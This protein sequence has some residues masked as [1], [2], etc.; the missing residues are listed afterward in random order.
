MLLQHVRKIMVIDC[1]NC[2]AKVDAKVLAQ[3][4]T[5]D[6]DG[7]DDSERF[8]FC[9]CPACSSILLAKAFFGQC[10]PDDFDYINPR[11]LWPVSEQSAPF[12]ESIPKLVRKSLNEARTCCQAR[13]YSASVVMS[14]RAIEAVCIEHKTKSR[15]LAGGIRELKAQGVIDGRLFDWSEALRERRNIGAHATEEDVSRE[16]AEDVLNFAIAIC[17]YVFVLSDRYKEFIVRSKKRKL[18]PGSS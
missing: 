7:P 15:T 3:K 10:S 4:V 17:E 6:H 9:Q 12:S 16:D 8:Y 11:L 1:P 14:G 18:P 2:D 13:A 5:G